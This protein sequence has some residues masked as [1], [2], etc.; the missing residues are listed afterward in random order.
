MEELLTFRTASVETDLEDEV[1]ATQSSSQPLP[2]FSLPV[3]S[4]IHQ[5]LI[6]ETLRGPSTRQVRQGRAR[7]LNSAPPSS[8]CDTPHTPPWQKKQKPEN[9]AENCFYVPVMGY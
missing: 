5:A 7:Y 8:F 2:G 4:Q 3:R 6:R 9:K 1:N